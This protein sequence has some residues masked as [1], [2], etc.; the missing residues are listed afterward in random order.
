MK[1]IYYPM[2]IKVIVNLKDVNINVHEL[3]RKI[4]VNW[5]HVNSIL[6][7]LYLYDLVDIDRSSKPT[8]FILTDDGKKIRELLWRVDEVI[9]RNRE[10]FV[11]RMY[12]FE[13]KKDLLKLIDDDLNEKL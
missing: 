7:T 9:K 10:R 3:A 2:I 4:Q 8:R 11:A 13:N 12:G 1:D 6:N 5:G